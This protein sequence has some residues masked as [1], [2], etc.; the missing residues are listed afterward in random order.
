MAVVRDK[1]EA[2]NDGNVLSASN[3]DVDFTVVTG[4]TLNID[5]AI[6]FS[7]T[8]AVLSIANSTSGGSYWVRNITS[9][10]T[11]GADMYI[12]WQTLPSAEITIMVYMTSASAQ[13]IRLNVTS[14]G[15]L[16][17]HDAAAG[18]GATLWTSTATMT[19]NTWYRISLFATQNATTGTVRAA[20]FVGT[21]GTAADD[22]TLL[23]GRNTG[24]GPYVAVRWGIKSSTSTA[25]ATAHIDDYAY[26]PAATDLLP[27]EATS[28]VLPNPPYTTAHYV[29]LDL[30]GTTYGVGPIEFSATPSSVN[31]FPVIDMATGLLLPVNS[32]GS[33]TAYTVTATDTG[34]GNSTDD[35]PFNAQLPADVIESVIW[36]GSAWV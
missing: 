32:D 7:G 22:S 2:G 16:R 31:G 4:G 1:F 21:S 27:V 36:S 28:P 34:A 9:A 33:I 13:A 6:A 23:T 8:R 26:D 24:S 25:T 30:T 5:T 35:M 19:T 20:Y 11:L 18:G 15:Q 10:T 17:L 29:Y 12:R 14:T 3:S